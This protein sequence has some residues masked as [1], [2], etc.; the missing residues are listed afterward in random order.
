[1]IFLRIPAKSISKY[2]LDN[3]IPSYPRQI[4]FFVSSRQQ[5]SFVSK[6][7]Q[8]L[9]IHSTMIFFRILAKSNSTYTLDINI[10]SYPPQLRL[11]V[12]TRQ[13]YSCV[14]STSQLNFY[15]V[16]WLWY[17][18]V[19]S[20]WLTFTYLV[21]SKTIVFLRILTC[22]TSSFTY[23]LDNDI[24]SCPPHLHFCF[25]IYSNKTFLWIIDTSISYVSTVTRH[26]LTYHS[27][28]NIL[29][30]PDMSISTLSLRSIQEHNGSWY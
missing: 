24:P 6:P 27:K 16:T 26:S 18:F 5:F 9:R 14:S 11:Y 8:F 13:W 20:H 28:Q 2:T 23:L 21:S 25:C 12:C 30:H 22:N 7:T 4:V 17:S 19:S 10:P 15:V 3:N 29:S 1:M